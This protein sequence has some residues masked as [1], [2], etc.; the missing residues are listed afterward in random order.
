MINARTLAYHALLHLER[1]AARPDVL[2]R[3]LLHRHPFLDQRDRALL[4]ELVYGVLRWRGRLDWHI[5]RISN[6]QPSKISPAVRQLLRLALYQVFFLERVPHHAAVNEAVRLAKATQPSHLAAF[7]NGVLR[8][9]VRRGQDW[10][11]PS[12]ESEPADHLAVTTSHPRW[13]IDRWLAEL[14][15]AETQALCRANNA[16]APMG[17]RVNTL[18]TAPAEAAGRLREQGLSVEA[19]PYLDYAL[20][21]LRPRQDITQT[22]LYE[23]GWIQIQDEGSQLV[24][25]LVA[26][27]PGERVL[28]LCS[29]FGGKA[30]Q[31]AMLMDN[32][33][34]VAAVDRAAWKLEHLRTN[35]LRQGVAIIHPLAGDIL[36]LAGNAMA[37]FDRVLLDAPCSGLGTLRRNPDI[38]WRRQFKDCYRFGQLQS[39]LLH[40]AGKW[41]KVGGVL[42]YAT[43]TLAG[44]ENLAVVERFEA[45]QAHFARESVESSLPQ[46]CRDMVDKGCFQSWPHRHGIDG[47][48]AARWRRTG[49]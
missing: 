26:P 48:F 46:T 37:P 32:T 35:A 41:V 49:D 24:A 27:R 31:L 7:V 6:V 39:E 13:L 28:D 2:L 47:F 16:V 22:P 17:L 1:Q 25:H 33:G 14:G 15:C 19:S 40:Q 10:D 20:R 8:T 5:D 4:T 36:E 3:S 11:W 21:L 45:G 12:P 34:E 29:G 30:T 9:A 42:V 43:C 44:E 18:K 38:K 23:E